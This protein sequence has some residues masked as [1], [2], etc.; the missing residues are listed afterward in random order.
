MSDYTVIINETTY[1]A[2]I[3]E[4][5]VRVTVTQSTTRIAP[6]F[7]PTNHT[8]PLSQITGHD[9][10]AHD[11]LGID[12]AT[13]GGNPPSAFAAANHT[14]GATDITALIVDTKANILSAT[15]PDSPAI[16]VATDSNELFWWNG[17]TWYTVGMDAILGGGANPDMGAYDIGGLGLSN[18]SG[19]YSNAITDKRLSN[20]IIGDSARD[21]DGSIRYRSGQLQF[22]T[23]GSWNEIVINFAFRQDDGGAYSLEYKPTGFDAW[24]IVFSGNSSDLVGLNG[25]PI[26]QQYQVSMGAYPPEVVLDGG[27]L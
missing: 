17:S 13:L 2:N 5:P 1:T 22:Y 24:V 10:A 15:P 11:A 14:H 26:V 25:L 18:R 9:K 27:T 6:E 4:S 21:E 19:Y 20:I 7:A 23:L 16:G 3:T 8:H 12:A